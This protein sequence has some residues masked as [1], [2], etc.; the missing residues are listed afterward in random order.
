MLV[1]T[2][3]EY[4][5]SRGVWLIGGGGVKTLLFCLGTADSMSNTED[6]E[7][8]W[9]LRWQWKDA[10]QNYYLCFQS[11]SFGTSANQC[12][13]LRRAYLFIFLLSHPPL[14]KAPIREHLCHFCALLL[15][16]LSVTMTGSSLPWITMFSQPLVFEGA[17]H[18]CFAVSERASE[19]PSIHIVSWLFWESVVIR[20][21]L[22][23]LTS[24]LCYW[25]E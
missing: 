1:W 5:A 20:D 4:S 18:L 14:T 6:I 16:M 21:L 17:L 8:S 10:T 25:Y 13:P 12:F 11:L 19:I 7:N 3:P 23:L 9:S 15:T 22:L 24:W 2:A